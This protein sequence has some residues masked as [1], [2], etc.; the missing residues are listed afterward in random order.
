MLPAV[1]A[2]I[3]RNMLFGID[4]ACL[5]FC[6]KRETVY[7]AADTAAECEDHAS[8]LTTLATRH[9]GV[10][11]QEIHDTLNR[12]VMSDLIDDNAEAL[13]ALAQMKRDREIIDAIFAR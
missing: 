7:I 5:L 1:A 10:S 3:R 2:A 11:M 9:A 6:H 8:F 13:D 4:R 12:V